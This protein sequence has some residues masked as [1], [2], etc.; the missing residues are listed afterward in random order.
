MS[1]HPMGLAVFTPIFSLLA[2]GIAL[3]ALQSP[4]QGVAAQGVVVQSAPPSPRFT[5]WVARHMP[6]GVPG[7]AGGTREGGRRIRG[8]IPPPIDLSHVHGPVFTTGAADP[9]YPPFFD[10][11]AAGDLTPVKDQGQ[12][13]TCWSFACM[14]SLESS[15]LKAGRGAFDLSEWHLAWFA[16]HPQNASL[17]TAFSP[18]P[19]GDLEDPV[20][21]QGGND[22]ISTALLARGTG[23]V[24]E[25][26][27][28][29]QPGAYRPEPRPAGDLPNGRENLS[30]PL[31][32]SLYLFNGDEPTSAADLKYALTHYGPAVISMDWEDR[33]F[34]EA[35]NTYRDPGATEADLNHEV[36]IVGWNDRFEP[37]RFPPCNRPAA[38][39]AWIVRNSWSRYWGQGGYFY[40][41]YDS[42]VFDG[43]VFR[44]GA[45]T[46]RRIHQYDP[47]GWVGSRGFGTFSAC[48]ANIFHSDE[49]ERVTAVA[50]YTGAV[51]T[52]YELDLRTGAPP[53][54]PASGTSASASRGWPPQMG[55]L[56]APGYHVVPLD[57]PVTVAKDSD[58]SVIVRLTTPGYPYPIPVQENQPGYSDS[59]TS[60]HGRSFISPDGA[61]WVDLSPD[62]HGAV[63][64]LKALAE[65][66]D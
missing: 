45:R 31:E 35:Q 12:Y 51:G 13:G 3:A 54:D 32:E 55:T 43:T 24:N 58:F 9:P 66:T 14:G 47:L 17:F 6:R 59:A 50:F 30:V 16:Y 57:S 42:R 22:W 60:Q 10:L 8:Y 26:D 4:A 5:D 28:P 37:C 52:R 2:A 41:S 11:R 19:V 62:C 36:C 27:C 18:G 46:S 21:D 48:A 39:G 25:L 40:L 56:Q 49:A 34:D 38:P 63:A 44:G 61:T 33:N 7:P 15:Q 65:K 64:C 20:F 23:A 29:Y 1:K 53:G